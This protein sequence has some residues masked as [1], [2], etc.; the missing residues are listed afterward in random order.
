MTSDCGVRTNGNC[1]AVL[2]RAVEG[3]M[4]FHLPIELTEV[5]NNENAQ[6]KKVEWVPLIN[7]SW[8]HLADP[9]RFQ[10]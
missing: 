5:A 8:P 6:I 10:S 2:Q 4:A 9:V 7:R 3:P 1:T